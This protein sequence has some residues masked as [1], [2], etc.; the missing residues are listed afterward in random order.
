M[1]QFGH[2]TMFLHWSGNPGLCTY[3]TTEP[4]PIRITT[5]LCLWIL[6][7][8]SR[9]KGALHLLPVPSSQPVVPR[10]LQ[11]EVYGMWVTGF[12]RANQ[13][14]RTEVPI[15]HSKKE[16]GAG[17][18]RW[19]MVAPLALAD[20]FAPASPYLIDTRGNGASGLPHRR[21]FAS[22]SER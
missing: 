21:R 12:C 5:S 22:C 3:S 15:P 7:I 17:G 16:W 8:H 9:S 11:K 20:H 1:P 6:I 14:E 19:V 4:H 2:L 10:L 13:E 18:E